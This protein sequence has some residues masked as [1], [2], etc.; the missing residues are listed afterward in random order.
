MRAIDLNYGI[1]EGQFENDNFN[2]FGRYISYDGEYY[3]GWFL[4][5]AKHGFGKY[6]YDD[7]KKREGTWNQ[8]SYSGASNLSKSI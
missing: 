7:G 6:V 1:Y 5:G 2:G 3:I 4:G 8:G